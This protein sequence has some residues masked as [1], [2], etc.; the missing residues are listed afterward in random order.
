M[1]VGA[2]H[3]QRYYTNPQVLGTGIS[4]EGVGSVLHVFAIAIR[5]VLQLHRNYV[6]RRPSYLSHIPYGQ[7]RAGIH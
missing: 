7:V 3:I 4:S 1:V 2:V 6:V 5:V